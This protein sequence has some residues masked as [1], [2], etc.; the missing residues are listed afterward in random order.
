M[1]SNILVLSYVLHKNISFFMISDVSTILLPNSMDEIVVCNC[2]FKVN[3]IMDFTIIC[4]SCYQLSVDSL[5][6]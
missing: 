6:H 1:K 3:R 4:C 5:T 2:L